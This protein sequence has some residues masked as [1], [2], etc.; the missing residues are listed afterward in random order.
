MAVN[1]EETTNLYSNNKVIYSGYERAV[2]SY[3]NDP[4]TWGQEFLPI[5]DDV[6]NNFDGTTVSALSLYEKILQDQAVASSFMKLVQEITGRKYFIDPFQSSGNSITSA[7]QRIADFC[8]EV[9]EP[10][11]EDLA[12]ALLKAYIIGVSHVELFW[13]RRRHSSIVS[14]FRYVP[15]RRIQYNKIWNRYLLTNQDSTKGI[16]LDDTNLYPRKFISHRYFYQADN[17][18][19]GRGL[20]QLLYHPVI[21]LRRAVE[22]WALC[23]DRYATPLAIATVTSDATIKEKK[24]I[25]KALMNLSRQRYVIMNQGWSIHFNKP[26]ADAHF[27]TDQVNSYT[28]MI[29]KLIS[30]ETTAGEAQMGGSYSRDSISLSILQKR[31]Q[32]LARGLANKLNKTLIRWLVDVNFGLEQPA[33]TLR[34]DFPEDNSTIDI[35]NLTALISAGFEMDRDWVEK[36]YKVKLKEEVD[37]TKDPTKNPR[38][39]VDKKERISDLFSQLPDSDD[40]LTGL[41][42]LSRKGS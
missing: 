10:L 42:N 29:N 9:V 17:T 39:D 31:A 6:L 20:G 37:A 28:N 27:F 11:I 32:S 34:W 13:E 2:A 3:T 5:K 40:E 7:D 38:L 26:Q 22:S 8:M 25:E 15:P 35:G 36:T 12:Q 1:P 24:E 33:P 14:G 30:G 21:F 16:P 4:L 19:Y 18:P 23:G 41:L